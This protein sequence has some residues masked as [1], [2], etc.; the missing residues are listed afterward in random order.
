MLLVTNEPSNLL[1]FVDVIFRED[2][3]PWAEGWKKSSVKLTGDI[4]GA[5]I[6]KVAEAAQPW[7]AT[8]GAYKGALPIVVG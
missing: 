5:V 6:P 8:G 3:L 4:V 2:R 7:K 1:R